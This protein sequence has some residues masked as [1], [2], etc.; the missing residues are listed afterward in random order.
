MGTLQLLSNLPT[1]KNEIEEIVNKTV[2]LIHS[3]EE[4]PIQCEV[5][6]KS[7]EEIIKRVR[8]QIREY[9]VIELDK[10]EKTFEYNGVSVTKSQRHTYDFSTCNDSVWHELNEQLTTLKDMIKQRENALKAGF[11]FDGE[12]LQKPSFATSEFITIKFK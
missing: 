1:T 3:G 12:I 9:V 7:M 8:E 6:L 5:A 11:S 2:D 10:Y 4:N